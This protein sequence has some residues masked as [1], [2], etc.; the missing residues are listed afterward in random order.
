MTSLHETAL[1]VILIADDEEANREMLLAMLRWDEVLLAKD[2]EEAVNLFAAV[3][4][5]LRYWMS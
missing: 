1:P 5:D 2:G 4:V 3:K